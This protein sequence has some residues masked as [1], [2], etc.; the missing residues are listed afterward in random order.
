MGCKE[1]KSAISLEKVKVPNIICVCC[2]SQYHKE[3]DGRRQQHEDVKGRREK[4]IGNP[5]RGGED[6]EDEKE[7]IVSSLR[8]S[9]DERHDQNSL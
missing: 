5:D 8:H 4:Q 9:Q 3:D 1:S 7:N 2:R 6:Q